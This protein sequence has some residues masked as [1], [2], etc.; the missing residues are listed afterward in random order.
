MNTKTV[1]IITWI[2]QGIMSVA[3]LLAGGMK[4][5][6]PYSEYV[7]KMPFAADFSANTILLIG[8][9]EILGVI[10]LN[11]PLI[12]KKLKFFSPLAAL[13]LAGTMIGAIQVHTSRSEPIAMQ[14]AFLVILLFIAIV[15]YK[16]LKVS[17]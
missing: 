14:V 13:G 9:L 11:L 8:V 5:A 15:R 7:E 2:L 10:G 17:K 4:L 3:F 1:N 12:I 16:Q 6:T